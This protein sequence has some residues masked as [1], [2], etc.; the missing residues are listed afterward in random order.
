MFKGYLS[1]LA[2]FKSP[3]CKIGALIQ[4]VVRLCSA[5]W[6]ERE[7]VRTGVVG[8]GQ[9]L[10]WRLRG[11]AASQ[12]VYEIYGC[13]PGAA[14]ICLVQLALFS[15]ARITVAIARFTGVGI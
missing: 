13:C 3:L 4:L 2:V 12:I 5:C 7:P 14:R 15:S 6:H 9:L 1:A 8:E 11:F 10:F